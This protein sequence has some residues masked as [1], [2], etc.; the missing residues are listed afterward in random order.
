MCGPR[1][2]FPRAPT[3]VC[4][5]RLGGLCRVGQVEGFGNGHWRPELGR[6]WSHFIE[7]TRVLHSSELELEPRHAIAQRHLGL[8]LGVIAVRRFTRGRTCGVH[9][10]GGGVR[11]NRDQDTV[12]VT[13]STPVRNPTTVPFSAASAAL[14]HLVV[15]KKRDVLLFLFFFQRGR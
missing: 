13:Q 8:I 7:Q 2:S 11:A 6:A 12:S 10:C 9:G 4:I 3:H 14:Q 15:A 5:F 1:E